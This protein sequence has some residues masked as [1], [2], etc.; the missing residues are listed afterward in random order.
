M[1]LII[2]SCLIAMPT[3]YHFL[4][5]WLQRYEYRIEMPWW[6]YVLTS[7]GGMLVTL[8]TVSFQAMRAAFLNPVNS[9]RSE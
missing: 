5:G 9:L 1:I 4:D 6:I 7:L 2:I 8:L 3:A